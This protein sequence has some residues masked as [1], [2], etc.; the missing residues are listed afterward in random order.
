MYDIALSMFTHLPVYVNWCVCRPGVGV[1][2]LL[3][4]HFILVL[5]VQ[6]LG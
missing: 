6:S 1:S 5:E 3:Q 4:S 2:C